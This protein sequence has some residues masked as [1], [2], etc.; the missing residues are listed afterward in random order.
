M[1]LSQ[2][3]T[4]HATWGS[5]RV[6]FYKETRMKKRPDL[7]E[8]TRKNMI[9]AYWKCLDESDGTNSVNAKQIATTAICCLYQKTLSQ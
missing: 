2:E 1:N 6:G 4:D 3:N 5:V 7:T 9:A 8:Q